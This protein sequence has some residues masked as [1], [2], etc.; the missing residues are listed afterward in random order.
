VE[1]NERRQ[2]AHEQECIEIRRD[3]KNELSDIRSD[4]EAN[5][6]EWKRIVSN[7]HLDNIRRLR[8]QNSLLISIVLSI[9]GFLGEKVWT[10]L[11]LP[12]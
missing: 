3:T 7:Q 11:Q 6:S 2:T 5:H 1:A 9:L 8:W 4:M 10:A 12:H